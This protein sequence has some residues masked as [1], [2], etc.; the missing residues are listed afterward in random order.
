M[1]QL[2][3][4]A[5]A[6]LLAASLAVPEAA[7]QPARLLR[8]LRRPPPGPDGAVLSRRPHRGRGLAG[9]HV[10]RVVYWSQGLRIT[11]YFL[12]PEEAGEEPP[13]LVYCHGGMAHG[14]T[15]DG[16]ILARLA[17]MAREG[18]YAVLASQYR[19]HDESDGVDTLGGD[20]VNDVVVL[21][22]VARNLGGVDAT[23]VGLLGESRGGSMALLAVA[24]GMAAR[25]VAVVGAPTDMAVLDRHLD[26]VRRRELR[27]AVGG[28]PEELPA[29]WAARSPIHRVDRIRVP[30]LQVHGSRDP[31]IPIDQAR[32]F[33]AALE[34]EGREVRLVEISG[35]DHLLARGRNRVRR[36]AE[37]AAW[38]RRH[39]HGAPAAISR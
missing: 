3:R 19:G 38:F 7:A 11:G 22:E 25:A 8:M 28:A 6:L 20:D 33:A 5:G 4:V 23:R 21:P 15:V 34:R 10:E 14:R 27:R 2:P 16:G 30:V 17:R 24:R 36:D 37:V 31:I 26:R 12:R 32:R 39:L 13:L 18:P 1:N 29:A 35:G 9:V